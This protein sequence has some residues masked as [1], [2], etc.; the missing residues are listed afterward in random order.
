[1]LIGKNPEFFRQKEKNVG[2]IKSTDGGDG[3]KSPP[4]ALP[5]MK[6]VFSYVVIFNCR[7]RIKL[8]S[9]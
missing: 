4:M 6:P 5:G 9:R 3:G 2:F 8:F 7:P 1:M